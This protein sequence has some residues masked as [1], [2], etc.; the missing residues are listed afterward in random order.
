VYDGFGNR[1]AF[2]VK[3]FDWCAGCGADRDTEEAASAA[4]G[5]A[6]ADAESDRIAGADAVAVRF[7]ESVSKSVRF[8]NAVSESVG[9]TDSNAES[10]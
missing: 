7:A 5:Y 3:R 2:C 10:D 1:S 4:D 9:N 6:V 8:A